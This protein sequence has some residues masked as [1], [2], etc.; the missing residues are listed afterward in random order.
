MDEKIKIENKI[1]SRYQAGDN[2]L[3]NKGVTTNMTKF[4]NFYNDNQWEG[5]ET[6]G[7]EMP[8]F[9]F[10]KPSI[11]Y[12][13]NTICQ[14]NVTVRFSDI[15]EED[16]P[17]YGILNKGF[18]TLWRKNSVNIK[19]WQAVKQ[20]GIEGD[21]FLFFGTG[22][23]NDAQIL[24]GPMILFGDEQNSSI[25]DQP[26]I[27]IRTRISVKEA[28]QL[29]KENNQNG[30]SIKGDERPLYMVGNKDNIEQND[31]EAMCTAVIY[32]QKIDGIVYHA[33]QVEGVKLKPLQPLAQ[34]I[35]GEAQKEGVRLYPIAHMSW[36]E[37]PN[38]ARGMGDVEGMIPNQINLNANLAR[39][40]I[41]TKQCAFP[42]LAVNI[43][44]VNNPED[45]DRIGGVLELN[46][47]AN[48]VQQMASFL[49]GQAQSGDSFNLNDM[50]MNYTRTLAGASDSALGQIDP[51]R[52]SGEAVNAISNQASMSLNE[53][54]AKRTQFIEDIARIYMDITVAFSTEGIVYTKDGKEVTITPEEL[55]KLKYEID[56]DI[57]PK[58]NWSAEDQQRWADNIYNNGNGPVEFEEYTKYLTP[59]NGIVPKAQIK[60]MF[61]QRNLAQPEEEE[62][63]E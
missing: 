13:V 24:S 57:A 8:F 20:A 63:A 14:N 16:N 40:V 44:A 60:E 2:Y 35:D 55:A 43:H 50:L 12:K 19:T 38:S 41:A 10:I 30:D 46:G 3:I 29:A 59:D 21:G 11:K 31:E 61:Q 49:P 18:E 45:L 26:Y 58:Y 33:M 53:Y 23:M 5:L 4:W 56:I 6:G 54:V 37:K 62:V 15:N 34:T 27:M 17:I 7:E 47:S 36:E 25:Q 22:D 1:W 42:K 48:S 39:I 28:R 9:N 52:V 51:T 32:M